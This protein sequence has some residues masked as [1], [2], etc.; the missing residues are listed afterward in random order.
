MIPSIRLGFVGTYKVDL[1]HYFSRLLIAMNKSVVIID[2]SEE[3]Y[4]KS[5]I[6]D[7][8]NN[9]ITYQG[10]DCKINSNNMEQLIGLDYSQ[11]DI[12]L[13]D[14][15]LNNKVSN[16]Y[17][18]CS[19]VFVITDFER[20]HILALQK[21][22][23][24]S[25]DQRIKVVKIYRDVVQSKIT[26]KYI[27]YL[28]DLDK[29]AKVLAEYVFEFKEEDYACKLLCQYNE[30]FSIKKVTKDYKQMF[31]DI[32]EEIYHINHREAIRVIKAAEEGKQ[33]K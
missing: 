19:I 14:Y 11:Y 15:G 13:I 18:N 17:I 32:I 26:T 8:I 2:A 22:I 27:N 23:F 20:H 21:L 6:P 5:T 25:F 3:Q 30:V 9:E 16:D 1:L 31:A 24:S 12:A 28:L 10:V 7:P 33:C 4:L 29:N